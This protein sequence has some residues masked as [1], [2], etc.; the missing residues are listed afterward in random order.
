MDNAFV[1]LQVECDGKLLELPE[2]IEGILLLNINSYMGGVNLWASG[3]WQPGRHTTAK[4]S[5]CDGRLEVSVLYPIKR[6]LP[7]QKEMKHK[8]WFETVTPL[9]TVSR[10]SEQG[11]FTDTSREQEGLSYQKIDCLLALFTC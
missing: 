2:D 3:A 5:I 1:N 6:T 4:Q 8:D 9:R 10:G 11:V 7:I